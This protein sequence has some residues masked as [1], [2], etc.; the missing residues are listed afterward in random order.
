M[1]RDDDSQ[2]EWY[3]FYGP[4]SEPKPKRRPNRPRKPSQRFPQPPTEHNEG[5]A[6]TGYVHGTKQFILETIIA[7]RNIT[8]E[9]LEQRVKDYGAKVSRVTIS[10]I[11]Q[12]TRDTLKTLDRMGLLRSKPSDR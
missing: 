5:P 3:P 12:Q 11:R 2:T 6:P 4:R 8:L 9:E 7:D 1:S 10:N